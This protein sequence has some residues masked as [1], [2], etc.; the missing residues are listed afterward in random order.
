MAGAKKARKEK[1]RPT[2]PVGPKQTTLFGLKKA[3]NV[4][5]PPVPAHRE[6]FASTE[7]DG[8]YEHMNETEETQTDEYEGQG[9]ILHETLEA[10]PEPMDD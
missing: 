6:S 1:E 3:T 2:P 10:S 8:D 9:A 4:P 7:T 5:I